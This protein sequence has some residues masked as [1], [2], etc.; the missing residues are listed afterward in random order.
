ML[1]QAL[2]DPSP[3]VRAI[4][5]VLLDRMNGSGPSDEGPDA[6]RSI[7]RIRAEMRASDEQVEMVDFGA[8]PAH[9][10]RTPE[11]MSRGVSSMARL[12]VMADRASSPPEWC[13]LMFDLIRRLRPGKC[14]ELGTNIGISAAYQ[15]SALRA[16]G[17]GELVTIEG[18]PGIARMATRT[19]ERLGL[20]QARVL[21]GRFTD[22]LPE[23]LRKEGPFDLVFIDG[24]HDQY[25]TMEYFDMIHPF[26][27]DHAVVIFDDIRWSDGMRQAW[28]GLQADARTGTTFDLDRWGVACTGAARNDGRPSHMVPFP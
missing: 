25:A 2:D 21:C 18:A 8:G 26:L 15:A 16:N 20:A 13:E 17:T 19:L 28:R 14:L 24:H 7:E 22:V 27:S 1:D 23:M 9:V 10:E 11:Q 6:I 3:E 4:A 12:S 5:G